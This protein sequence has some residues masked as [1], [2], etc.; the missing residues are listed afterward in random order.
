MPPKGSHPT[1]LR[2]DGPIVIDFG[3]GVRIQLSP[4]GLAQASGGSNATPVPKGKPG[5]RPGPAT[6]KLVEAMQA[7]AKAGGPR[8][9]TEYVALLQDAGGPKTPNGAGLIVLREAKRIFG[10]PL[11]R[12]K[13]AKATGGR[14]GHGRQASPATALL[15]EKLAADKAAGGL[16][17]AAHY[18][19]WLMDQKGHGLGLKAGRPIVYRELRAAKT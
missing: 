11:G 3:N 13:K 8:S 12:G 15:R 19:R 17:D 18:L 14:H 7:D 10:G 5:R 9:R 1:V 2:V 16:R 6:L 4:A